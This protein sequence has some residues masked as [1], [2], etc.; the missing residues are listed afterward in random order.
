MHRKG[1]F[2]PLPCLWGLQGAQGSRQKR[3]WNKK[4]LIDALKIVMSFIFLGSPSCHCKFEAVFQCLQCLF[5][6]QSALFWVF[7]TGTSFFM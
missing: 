3:N 1:V 2:L 7:A 4:A 5:Y 6:G